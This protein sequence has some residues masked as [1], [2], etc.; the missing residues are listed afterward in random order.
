MTLENIREQLQQM[1]GSV[2][3]AVSNIAKVKS[4]D[5][6]KATCTLEDEDGQEILEVRL[7]PVLSGKKSFLQIPK[8]GSFVLAI[9]IE[10]DSDW[11]IISCDEVEKFVWNTLQ[12]EVEISDKIH[13]EAGGENLLDLMEKLFQ[14]IERGY[15]TNT[16]T[17]I[18]LIM[19]ND[20]ERLK[21][22][23]QTLLK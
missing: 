7:R 23:F 3:P 17:T 2:G 11:M 13:I 16:G 10:D 20:F 18:R 14:I 4:V 1:A 21:N 8:V 22:D 15:Q 9:R 12:A 5:E 19:Q 6:S